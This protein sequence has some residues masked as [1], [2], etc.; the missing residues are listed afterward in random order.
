MCHFCLCEAA[1]GSG[2]PDRI[3]RPHQQTASADNSHGRVY[4]VDWRHGHPAVVRPL[5]AAPQRA[6]APHEAVHGA[7]PHDWVAARVHEARVWEQGGEVLEDHGALWWGRAAAGAGLKIRAWA[8]EGACVC[9]LRASCSRYE[10]AGIRHTRRPSF[11]RG[12]CARASVIRGA[13]IPGY[14]C[15][16][17]TRLPSADS[18]AAAASGQPPSPAGVVGR[19]RS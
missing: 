4:A 13:R 19:G 1:A 11:A 10:C 12:G 9:R 17:H 16:R 2:A 6:V 7:A 14:Q 15:A 5:Q 8:G 3:S 18:R